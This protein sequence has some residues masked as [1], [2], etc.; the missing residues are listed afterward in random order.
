[1]I[2]EAKSTRYYLLTKNEPEII[3][4]RVFTMTKDVP[5]SDSFNVEVL[6]FYKI[7]SNKLY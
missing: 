2:K 4:Y 7:L 6:L 3:E 1:M 5:Y